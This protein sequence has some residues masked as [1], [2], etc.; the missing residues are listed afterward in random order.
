MPELLQQ[1]TALIHCNTTSFHSQSI[2]NTNKIFKAVTLDEEKFMF[3]WVL[4][5]L[6]LRDGSQNSG[7]SKG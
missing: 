7:L 5:N 6:S 1:F 4:K 3:A 2:S